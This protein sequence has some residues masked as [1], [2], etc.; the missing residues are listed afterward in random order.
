LIAA[1]AQAFATERPPVIG[2]AVSGGG[3]S[4]ALLHLMMRAAPQTGWR[5]E[6]ATV[7]HG[8]RP[9]AA[10]EARM[11]GALCRD[12]NIPHQVLVWADPQGP[13]N[14]MDRARRA[15]LHL[16]AGWATARG[17]GHVALGHTADDQAETLLMG[18]SR[19]AGID[20]LSGMRP[21]FGQDGVIF[22]RP[23]LHIPR[24]SLRD[25]LAARHI[26]WIDDPSNDN[27]AFARV[28]ARRTV[29]ALKPLGITAAKLAAVTEHLDM[30]RAALDATTAAAA[31]RILAARDGALFL[32][33]P[34]FV[35]EPAEIR[36]R[37]V[38]AA[39][40]WITGPGY[41]PREAELNRLLWALTTG[42]DAT[43]RGS[44]IRARGDQA[45]IRREYRAVAGLTAA[46]GTLWDGRWRIE[47]PWQG[48]EAIRALGPAGLRLCPGWRATG[49]PR[50]VLEVTPAVWRGDALIAAPSAGFGHSWAA[51]CTPAPYSCQLSH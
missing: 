41:P 20:G 49:L 30:A 5:V 12:W 51:T 29:K 43:L 15:R 27:D 32:D 44:L 9:E 40:R 19:A 8:L 7:D 39:L 36:R 18:L 14:L 16:L 25:Y 45:L 48:D 35:A 33:R 50:G 34:A 11:V 3:D 17:I 1:A 4:L 22:A 6:A 13:G 24:Q 31:R 23:L 46:R 47:G 10:D 37:L 42:R 26:G 28:R 38:L 21:A 2:V